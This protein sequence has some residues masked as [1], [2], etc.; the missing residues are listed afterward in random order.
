MEKAQKLLDEW[1]DSQGASVEA[2]NQLFEWA[3]EKSWKRFAK[4]LCRKAR[5]STE[6][7]F[8]LNDIYSKFRALSPDSIKQIESLKVFLKKGKLLMKD[9]LARMNN[10]EAIYEC[11]SDER[12]ESVPA[13]NRITNPVK[14]DWAIEAKKEAMNEIRYLNEIQ[15]LES[16]NKKKNAEKIEK[17]RKLITGYKQR[18]ASRILK[19]FLMSE[20]NA[21]SRHLSGDILDCES[22][23]KLVDDKVNQ[24]RWDKLRP[25]EGAAEVS[26][27]MFLSVFN[28]LNCKILIEA[29]ESINFSSE[30]ELVDI[31]LYYKIDIEKML[32][33]FELSCPGKKLREIY[34]YKQILGM[35]REQI[36]EQ[37]KIGPDTVKR[38]MRKAKELVEKW[39]RMLESERLRNF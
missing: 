38:R 36:G 19:E 23:E 5:I 10:K 14:I 31:S 15:N 7:D 11:L 27:S 12:V 39:K 16:E 33:F 9:S 8:F 22:V 35:N 4:T 25:G 17:K 6:T 34:C 24:V 26:V 20:L 1:R 29:Q 13:N 37:L 3:R 2:L 32:D 18:E 30:N 28:D 21:K